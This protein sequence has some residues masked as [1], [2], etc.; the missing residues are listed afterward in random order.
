MKYWELQLQSPALQGWVALAGSPLTM[1]TLLVWFHDTA[2]P[3]HFVGVH[4]HVGKLCS[5]A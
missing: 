4:R 1:G 5:L 3:K 2:V